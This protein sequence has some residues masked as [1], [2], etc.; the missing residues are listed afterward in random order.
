MYQSRL[1]KGGFGQAM[2]PQAHQLYVVPMRHIHQGRPTG[3]GRRA[4][5][6]AIHNSQHPKINTRLRVPVTL[7]AQICPSPLGR[8]W[9][10]RV[11]HR[12]QRLRRYP[13]APALNGEGIVIHFC[14][15]QSLLRGSIPTA[16]FGHP[17]LIRAYLG[18][19]QLAISYS[20][21]GASDS[22]PSTPLAAVRHSSVQ[23]V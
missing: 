6:R 9:G 23:Q 14:P 8:T 5:L 3:A 20:R 11:P 4:R 15:Y 16:D 1:R 2:F 13:R 17:Q 12:L 19:Y 22:A 7:V 21:G 10:R 18:K